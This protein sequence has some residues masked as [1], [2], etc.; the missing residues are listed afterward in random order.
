VSICCFA[1]LIFDLWAVSAFALAHAL[2]ALKG[3][4][5]ALA[6]AQGAHEVA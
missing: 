2:S 3:L 1:F 6:L 4:Q 5:A